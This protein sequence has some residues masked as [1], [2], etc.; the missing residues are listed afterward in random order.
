[1]LAGLAKFCQN[2]FYLLRLQLVSDHGSREATALSK[3]HFL[4]SPISS[5]TFEKLVRLLTFCLIPLAAL[6]SY[7]VYGT[8][9]T[10]VC[11]LFIPP[12]LAVFGFTLELFLTTSY[13]FLFLLELKRA[14]TRLATFQR[15]VANKSTLPPLN[16]VHA[17]TIKIVSSVPAKSKEILN[18][19]TNTT[20]IGTSRTID[21]NATTST[22]EPKHDTTIQSQPGVTLQYNCWLTEKNEK[23][24]VNNSPNHRFNTNTT[25]TSDTT[26]TGTIKD[27]EATSFHSSAVTPASATECEPTSVS[28]VHSPV[29]SLVVPD[30]PSR[31]ANPMLG[32][33]SEFRLPARAVALDSHPPSVP[34]DI[35]FSLMNRLIRVTFICVVSAFM[36]M[37]ILFTAA[38]WDVVEIN[39]INITNVDMI[40]NLA[41]ISYTTSR[42]NKH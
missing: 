23:T 26:T 5:F 38:V 2:Y 20:V 24:N 14:R 29:H 4:P 42:K 27:I 18:P 40:I 32:Q 35:Y 15:N 36:T 28:P 17:E 13:F 10:G 31:P 1:M 8:Y 12:P 33:P 9:E 21:P 6:Y 34:S 39:V 19:R 3:F 11:L 41:C 30:L 7:L 22:P 37:A 16:S 25:T